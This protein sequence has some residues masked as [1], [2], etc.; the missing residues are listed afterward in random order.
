MTA[1]STLMSPRLRRAAPLAA[2]SAGVFLTGVAAAALMPV[3]SPASPAPVAARAPD[4]IHTV[5]VVPLTVR[6]PAP[7]PAPAHSPGD[8]MAAVDTVQAAG[9]DAGALP[10]QAA[11]ASASA[12]PRSQA[13]A[14]AARCP[15]GDCAAGRCAGGGRAVSRHR[16]ASRQGGR[17]GHRGSGAGA[18]ARGRRR[19]RRRA[20]DRRRVV[21]HGGCRP[22]RGGL[23]GRAR[24]R[25]GAVDPAGLRQPAVTRRAGRS[26]TANVTSARTPLASE[27][28]A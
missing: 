1:P 11:V 16:H 2:L 22:G 18:G 12:D 9:L 7:A 23:R 28:V 25:P 24:H 10:R 8:P 17:P 6:P 5:D 15:S 26:A 20:D 13:P 19:R 3:V 27:R 21:R 14:R 4:P